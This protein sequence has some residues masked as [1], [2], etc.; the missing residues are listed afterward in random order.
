MISVEGW[1][2]LSLGPSWLIPKSTFRGE[3][4]CIT[5]PSKALNAWGIPD[6]INAWKNVKT[7]KTWVLKVKKKQPASKKWPS[8][9]TARYC[10][11]QI[12]ALGSPGHSRCCKHLD[13]N[14]SWTFE[15]LKRFTRRN[16]SSWNE[17]MM[18]IKSSTWWCFVIY[19]FFKSLFSIS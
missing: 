1:F 8:P 10:H 18:I 11:T 4:Y 6:N 13:R 3:S 12:P 14:T 9:P 16:C 7:L 15:L 19:I 2:L 17:V 5:P